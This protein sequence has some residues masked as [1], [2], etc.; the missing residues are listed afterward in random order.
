MKSKE[1]KEKEIK[2][3]HYLNSKEVKS[4]ITKRNIVYFAPWLQKQKLIML[5]DP[6]SKFKTENL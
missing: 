1:V 2:S 3:D 5:H 4:R 6:K